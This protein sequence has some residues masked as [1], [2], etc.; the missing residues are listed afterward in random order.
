M[1]S[2]VVFEIL[3]DINGKLRLIGDIN[4]FC[5]Y[6]AMFFDIYYDPTTAALNAMALANK[7]VIKCFKVSINS[8]LYYMLLETNYV[9][10]FQLKSLLVVWK[11]I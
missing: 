3:M 11:R 5:E 2:P 6:A 1:R 7:N 10:N 4:D 8:W 9:V